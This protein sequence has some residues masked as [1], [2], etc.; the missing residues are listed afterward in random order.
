[1]SETRVPIPSF[2]REQLR[3]YAAVSGDDNLIHYDDDSAKAV[4]FD[5][6]IVH[7]MLSMAALGNYIESAYPPERFKLEKFESR[8]RKVVYPGDEL[9][10]T[11]TPVQ[12]ELPGCVSVCLELK[13]GRGEVAC[14]GAATMR[15]RA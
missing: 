11:V 8:F 9:F 6:V 4:G 10:C 3:E 15:P 7:G 14:E 2:T 5:G 13:N 12:P 1:M